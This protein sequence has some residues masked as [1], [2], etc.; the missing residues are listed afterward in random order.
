MKYFTY[1]P[2]EET[3]FII[4]YEEENQSLWFKG[5]AK[6]DDALQTWLPILEDF[7]QWEKSGQDLTVHFDFDFLNTSSSKF[8][9]TITRKLDLLADSRKIKIFWHYVVEDEDMEDIGEMCQS[10]INIKMIF[11]KKK[12]PKI[13]PRRK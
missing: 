10:V 12:L 6:P 7:D 4:D 5:K 1:R 13:T 3:E 2:K 8:V 11:V 9:V